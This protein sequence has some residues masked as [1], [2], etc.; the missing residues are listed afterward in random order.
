M[1]G[2]HGTANY[3]SVRCAASFNRSGG[4]AC[5]HFCPKQGKREKTAVWDAGI[6]CIAIPSLV[7]PPANRMYNL[8]APSRLGCVLRS[9]R[10]RGVGP[11]RTYSLRL[12][13]SVDWTEV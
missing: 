9:H 1:A 8:A 4:S 11:P 10:P 7:T 3:I 12:R 2:A 5:R 13:A 6:L